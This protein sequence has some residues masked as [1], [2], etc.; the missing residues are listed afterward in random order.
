M[1]KIARKQPF[2]IGQPR[3]HNG[4]LYSTRTWWTDAERAALPKFIE[5][6]YKPDDVAP[7]L[8]R[9]PKSMAYYA[10]DRGIVL[11]KEWASF[12]APRQRI[13]SPRREPLTYPYI[14][15]RKAEHADLLALNDLVPRAYPDHMRADICQEMMLAVIEGTVTIDEIKA[16]REKSAWFLKKFWMAN[17]EDRG[18]AISFQDTEEG[19]NADSVASNI[20]RKEWHREQFA[21]RTRFVGIVRTFV[22]PT[23][24]EDTWINQIHRQAEKTGL[25][26]DEMAELAENAD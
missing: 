20:A 10:R 21:E 16:N 14:I 7:V 1:A 5:G 19:W 4:G 17:Y 3:Y 2:I 13:L 25:S 6:G 11:P 9:T 18:H 12:I 23:Q 22:P 8:G 15:T 24:F 26:F